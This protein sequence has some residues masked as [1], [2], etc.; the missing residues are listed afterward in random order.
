M[1]P[2]RKVLTVGIAILLLSVT[3]VSAYYVYPKGKTETADLTRVA[4]VGD[5]ITELTQYPEDL[6]NMLGANSTVMNFGVTGSTVDFNSVKPYIFQ[7]A[8]QEA[9]AFLPTIVII[10]LGTNDARADVYPF[11]GS[12]VHDYEQL[13]SQ[14]Q[15]LKSK[16]QIF[17]VKPPPIFSNDLNI[18]SVDLLQGVIPN[19]EQV[20]KETKLPLVD[21]HAP[22]TKHP[23]YFP[24]GVHPNDEGAGIIATQIYAGITLGD[25][26]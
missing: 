8:F 24:D 25:K 3:I 11:I 21:V 6:Q 16:P 13:I 5:S 12:F 22:L 7:D 18:S 4:C 23:E 20:A 19:I 2:K 26:T 9:K 15:T 17:L 1:K 10:L 14:F